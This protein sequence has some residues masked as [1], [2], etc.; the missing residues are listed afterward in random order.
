MSTLQVANI[1]FESTGN[2]Y[3]QF[4][5]PN[6]VNFFAGGILSM[7]V[8]STA[9]NFPN[10]LRVSGQQVFT[11]SNTDQTITGGALVT[12]ANLG[13]INTGTLTPDPGA[14]PMQHYNANGAH[15]L[16]PA[17]NNGFYTLD[18]TMG[19]S[20]GVITTSGWTKVIGDA[21]TTTSGFKYRCSASIGN[22]GS[23]L[24]VQAMQ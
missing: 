20:A 19:A 16:A 11:L 9:V 22:A 1:L 2:N 5:S 13:T 18:I 4:S 24:V 10:L 14:R 21:L 7:T 6:S 23:L 17:A 8:N 12:S 3:L 15:T